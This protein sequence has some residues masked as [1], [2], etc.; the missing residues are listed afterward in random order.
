MILIIFLFPVTEH[1]M[2]LVDEG[3]GFNIEV[4][5]PAYFKAACNKL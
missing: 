5:A 1:Y 3:G 4:A 2:K